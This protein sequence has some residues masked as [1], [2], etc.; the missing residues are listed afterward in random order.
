MCVCISACS[1]GGVCVC[2]LCVCVCDCKCVCALMLAGGQGPA[3]VCVCVWSLYQYLSLADC[4]LG[5]FFCVSSNPFLEDLE[6]V[7]CLV[8]CKVCVYAC[9]CLVRVVV[10]V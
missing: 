9:V 3:N 7:E 10:D 2:V 8:V 4:F 6:S 5:K 1:Y